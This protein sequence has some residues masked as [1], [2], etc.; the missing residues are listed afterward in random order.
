M[1]IFLDLVEKRSV[2]SAEG[3]KRVYRSLV[4]RLHPDSSGESGKAV[5][6][7]KLKLD[8]HEAE[9]RLEEIAAD[10]T[11]GGKG[12]E[13]GAFSKAELIEEFRELLA[14]GFPIGR[15]AAEKNKEY[16][17]SIQRCS[18][19]LSSAFGQKDFLAALDSQFAE[20]KRTLPFAWRN[21]MQILWNLF[22]AASTGMEPFAKQAR[23]HY[24]FIK[25]DLENLRFRETSEFFNYLTS[26]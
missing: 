16:R 19:L 23:M 5:D 4:K 7:D 12:E 24:H 20:I 17:K 21:S 10:R 13:A 8:F 26:D 15:K 25:A 22:D 1:N 9:R 3:L 18:S 14:R 6:L 2:T 11:V